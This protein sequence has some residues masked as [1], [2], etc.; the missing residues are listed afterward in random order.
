MRACRCN[1]CNENQPKPAEL[2]EG[3][4]YLDID[5]DI[6]MAVRSWREGCLQHKHVGCELAGC[7]CWLLAQALIGPHCLWMRSTFEYRERRAV[8]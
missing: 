4:V 7:L 5:L 2:C 6:D 3:L 1:G 8:N